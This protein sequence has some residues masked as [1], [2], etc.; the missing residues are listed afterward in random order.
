M[1]L[2]SVVAGVVGARPAGLDLQISPRA[3]DRRPWQ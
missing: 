3:C 1:E 2:L